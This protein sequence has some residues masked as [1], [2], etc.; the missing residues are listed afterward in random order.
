MLGPTPAGKKVWQRLQGHALPL[1]NLDGMDPIVCGKLIDRPFPTDRLE[2][3]FRL[4]RTTVL[5]SLC[6]HLLVLPH[7]S[8]SLTYSVVQFLGSIIQLIKHITPIRISSLCKH[9][10]HHVIINKGGLLTD[11]FI[12]ACPRCPSL[13]LPVVLFSFRIPA[14]VY[15]IIT[16]PFLPKVAQSPTN[17]FGGNGGVHFIFPEDLLQCRDIAAFIV[18][19]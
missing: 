3:H 15:S 17:S 4:E 7:G 5:P 8:M 19:A 16:I 11:C 9:E 2:S 10:T 14:T 6:R 12:L 18:T 13:I 1:R